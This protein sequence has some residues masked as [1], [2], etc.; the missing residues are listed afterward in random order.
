MTADLL[1]AWKNRRHA[2]VTSIQT[3]DWEGR[4]ASITAIDDVTAAVLLVS[5]QLSA[6]VELVD[7]SG[8]AGELAGEAIARRI[9]HR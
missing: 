8:D 1:A 3:R 6:L 2:L 5:E 7:V 4:P 9:E